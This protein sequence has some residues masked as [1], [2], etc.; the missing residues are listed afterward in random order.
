[1][2]RSMFRVVLALACS[3]SVANAQVGG[4]IKKAIGDKVEKNTQKSDSKLPGDPVDG[5]TLDALLKGLTVETRGRTQIAQLEASRD[6]KNTEQG[7]LRTANEAAQRTWEQGQ[8]KSS[9]CIHDAMSAA[10]QS[11]QGD[12]QARMMKIAGDPAALQQ[13]QQV[14]MEFSQNYTKLV[15]AK[16]TAG[17]NKLLMAYYKAYGLDVMADSNAAYAKC[18]RP[19]A[20]PAALVRADALG[21]EADSLNKQIRDVEQQTTVQA[22]TAA[23]M[24]ADKYGLA[25]ER[26]LTWY[27]NKSND[28]KKVTKAE[29]TLFKSRSSDIE[30]VSKVLK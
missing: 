12:M 5:S 16:D 22:V 23:G 2:P 28:D 14:T 17:A 9:E 20:K 6:A 30:R 13:L 18:G 26:L 27:Q 8:S 7:R 3:A 4:L 11:H 1:M 10:Q 15:A 25:R 24:T 19:P 29:D 21:V